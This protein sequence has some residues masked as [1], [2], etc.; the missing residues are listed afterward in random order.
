M[1]LDFIP[2]IRLRFCAIFVALLTG[3]VD[4]SASRGVN[5]KGLAQ[6]VAGSRIE[7]FVD[8][9]EKDPAF[10]LSI[11]ASWRKG[12]A[13]KRLE[14]G[15]G[16]LDARVEPE[17]GNFAL[18]SPAAEEDPLIL[19]ISGLEADESRLPFTF[20]ALGRLTAASLKGGENEPADLQV[21]E[22]QRD[23]EDPRTALVL[24]GSQFLGAFRAFERGDDAENPAFPAGTGVR[25]FLPSPDGDSGQSEFDRIA[26]VAL[27]TIGQAY[28]S[29]RA[30]PQANSYSGSEACHLCIVGSASYEIE[31]YD[32]RHIYKIA[33]GPPIQPRW[34]GIAASNNK[35]AAADAARWACATDF[36]DEYRIYL[37][38]LIPALENE[39]SFEGDASAYRHTSLDYLM[40]ER[41]TERSRS[42]SYR[43][44]ATME[45]SLV[46]KQGA[47]PRC[48]WS[49]FKDIVYPC[50]TFDPPQ[51]LE[52]ENGH[53]LCK[54]LA[55]K[56]DAPWYVRS[57]DQS[58]SD[59]GTPA[60]QLVRHDEIV[61]WATAEEIQ[62]M[63]RIGY[64]RNHFSSRGAS[65]D[66]RQTCAQTFVTYG[67][68]IAQFS[69]EPGLNDPP[70]PTNAFA[71]AR[72]GWVKHG[73]SYPSPGDGRRAAFF[74][75]AQ[76][77]HDLDPYFQVCDG[78][79]V[80]CKQVQAPTGYPTPFLY[81]RV[82]LLDDSGRYVVTTPVEETPGANQGSEL[83][84][85]VATPGGKLIYDLIGPRA[86]SLP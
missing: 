48:E 59:L 9:S 77:I 33:Q 25:S 76:E 66:A 43:G 53:A 69:E 35:S 45:W 61:R 52:P 49:P 83:Q 1:F 56:E 79:G 81:R 51:N 50:K 60:L 85:P 27:A 36:Q 80:G 67:L 20:A 54:A 29:Y 12:Q 41:W 16:A 82:A 14:A 75:K 34:F 57:K 64:R 78:P 6:Q 71:L 38:G 22:V 10:Y 39:P 13:L 55:T 40:Y 7:I 32:Q 44:S 24:A 31:R 15:L 30:K 68:V 11:Q 73:E 65:Q 58:L 84:I 3:C 21:P 62:R 37:D 23:I 26:T 8:E 74:E 42:A 46:R 28:R 47:A 2:Q 17:E 63:N 86:P 72:V 70:Q 5:E 19:R 4:E 18:S